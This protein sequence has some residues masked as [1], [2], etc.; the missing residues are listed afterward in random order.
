MSKA[1]ASPA[2]GKVSHL[3]VRRPFKHAT[4]HKSSWDLR[5]ERDPAPGK[6][7]CFTSFQIGIARACLNFPGK[8][9]TRGFDLFPSLPFL[10]CCFVSFQQQYTPSL[11]I[12][13][14]T[15]PR[16]LLTKIFVF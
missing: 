16:F 5:G 1:P 14:N 11:Y 8:Q 7:V 13:R 6:R 12:L 2:L 15:N 9:I 4:V 3:L 10:L